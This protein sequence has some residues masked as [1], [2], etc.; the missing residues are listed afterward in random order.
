[1]ETLLPSIP[2]ALGGGTLSVWLIVGGLVLVWLALKAVKFV[3]RLALGGLAVALVMGTVPWA[4]SAVEGAPAD[5]AAAAVVDATTGWQSNLTKRV[6]AEEVSD[7]AR[8]REDGTGLASGSAVVRS[9]SFYDLPFQTW[10]VTAD[11]A[12]SRLDL[13]A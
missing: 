11:G 9:R 7:D 13:P 6:T 10:D 1:M 3:V 12:V 4:G 2:D 5:C 8:C